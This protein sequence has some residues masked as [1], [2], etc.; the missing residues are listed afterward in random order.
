MSRATQQRLGLLLEH[1]PRPQAAW[2]ARVF[3]LRRDFDNRLAFQNGGTVGF[4]RW[5]TG[6]GVSYQQQYNWKS[7]AYRW[8]AG[9]DAEWQADDRHRY[10]NLSGTRG[11][12]TLHQLETFGTLGVFWLHELTLREKWTLSG[13]LRADACLLYTSPSPRD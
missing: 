6:G 7:T 5:F 8:Q 12:Q 3:A 11:S 13:N 2:Q 4:E 9:A 1:R 10:D